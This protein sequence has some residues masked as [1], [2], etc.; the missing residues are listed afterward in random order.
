MECPNCGSGNCV[1]RDGL[2]GIC[3]DCDTVWDVED[4]YVTFWGTPPEREVI[5][6]PMCGGE[7]DDDGVCLQCGHEW[8]DGNRCHICGEETKVSD[9]CWGCQSAWL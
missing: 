5:P 1:A 3:S 4:G 6:C 8:Y 2:Q 9:V 7:F